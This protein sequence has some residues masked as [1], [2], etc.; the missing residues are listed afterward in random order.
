MNLGTMT[1]PFKIS[2]FGGAVDFSAEL[3][4]VEVI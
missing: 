3:R 2:I 4:R 1:F